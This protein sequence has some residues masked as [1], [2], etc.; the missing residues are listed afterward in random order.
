MHTDNTS[1]GAGGSGSGRFSRRRGGGSQ[2]FELNLAP[3]IDCMTV[4]IAFVL[5]GASY[6]SVGV[7]EAGTA[8]AGAV[9]SVEDPSSVQLTIELKNDKSII[10]NLSGRENRSHRIL[11][12]GDKRNYDALTDRL[13]IVKGE[14]PALKQVVV[15]ADNTVDYREVVKSM[16][17]TRKAVPN[18]LLGGF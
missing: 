2:E 16:E 9:Q 1:S 15:S 11:P 8:T 7:L 3:I 12:R 4:L 5:V 17:I 14:W 10:V 18:V 13:A 6:L